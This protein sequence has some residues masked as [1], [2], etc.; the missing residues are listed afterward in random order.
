MPADKPEP[1][2]VV[3]RAT[4]RLIFF[5][6]AVVAI[7]I[8]LLAIDLP[9][10]EGSSASA[11]WASV[12]HSG[13]HYVAFLISFFVIAGAWGNHHDTFAY[14]T[15][16][17]R[18]LRSLNFCW[19]FTIVLNP[20]ATKLLTTTGSATPFRF[21][22][23]AL[24]QVLST[25]VLFALLRHMSSSGLVPDAPSSVIRD[26]GFQAYGVMIAFG[27]SIPIFF[28]TSYGWIL[29]I[30]AP[31]IIGRLSRRSWGPQDPDL[32][33]GAQPK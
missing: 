10:P 4:E 14:T 33:Q 31:M 9:V 11:F 17:D 13:G 5:S 23:Y 7:A 27:L 18:R 22:F 21:G 19:L 32:S 15:R 30:L 24:L 12:R 2:F 3:S 25:A 8:T 6:D 20:F 28:V 1:D 29:W 16:V 26:M